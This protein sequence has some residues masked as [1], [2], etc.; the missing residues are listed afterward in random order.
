LSGPRI[1]LVRQRYNAA[2]GAER[3]V[4]RAMEALRRD[5]AEITLI[6]RRWQD[7]GSAGIVTLDPFHIGRTWR[8]WSFARAVCRHVRETRYDRV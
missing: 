7:G 6:T 5:G 4:S 3:F 2:G 8:D 1:A